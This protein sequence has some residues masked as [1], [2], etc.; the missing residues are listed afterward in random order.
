MIPPVEELFGAICCERGAR[1][2]LLRFLLPRY[3]LFVPQLPSKLRLAVRS[4]SL[5]DLAHRPSPVFFPYLTT[6]T[7]RLRIERFGPLPRPLHPAVPPVFFC[8][9]FLQTALEDGTLVLQACGAEP[10]RFPDTPTDSS[11]TSCPF[12]FGSLYSH[13]GPLVFLAMRA[14][15]NGAFD[16][17]H[18]T[19]CD[20]GPLFCR[21][22]AEPVIWTSR[23]F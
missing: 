5:F 19:S 4:L 15:S 21:Y 20:V 6:E 3:F 8:V 12:P 18:L 2:F 14:G 11:E 1:T 23:R 17:F 7:S 9:C 10:C 13:P 16:P 22:F